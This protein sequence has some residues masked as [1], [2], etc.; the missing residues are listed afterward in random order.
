MVLS[1]G[2][3]VNNEVTSKFARKQSK[4]CRRSSL[5]KS[6][7]FLTLCSLEIKS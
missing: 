2:M 4:F 6:E 1:S 5:A 7:E 3:L